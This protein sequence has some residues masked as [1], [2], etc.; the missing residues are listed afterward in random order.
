MNA[1]SCYSHAFLCWTVSGAFPV[2]GRPPAHPDHD[3]TTLH[4]PPAAWQH[5]LKG[6]DAQ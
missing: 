4:I 3:P 1:C 2:Q 5:D 6:A